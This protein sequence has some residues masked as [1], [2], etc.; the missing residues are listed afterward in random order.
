MSQ[1]RRSKQTRAK[2]QCVREK[3][4]RRSTFVAPLAKRASGREKRK[5][6]ASV[7]FLVD[8]SD[9]KGGEQMCSVPQTP[10]CIGSHLHIGGGR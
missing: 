6:K 4:R 5:K 9:Q 7:C 10:E 1:Q 8:R 3:G 2:D